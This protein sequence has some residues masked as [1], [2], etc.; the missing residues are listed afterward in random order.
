MIA[1]SVLSLFLIAAAVPKFMIM[2]GKGNVSLS[3]HINLAVL[4]SKLHSFLVFLLWT[5][6][7]GGRT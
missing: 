3:W 2:K 5:G 1:G 6:S 7:L 4:P